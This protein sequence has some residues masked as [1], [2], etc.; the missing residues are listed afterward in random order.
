MNKHC[1]SYRAAIVNGQSMLNHTI[2]WNLHTGMNKDNIKIKSNACFTPTRERS[3]PSS[4]CELLTFGTKSNT[5]FISL[6]TCHCKA[7]RFT[8]FTLTTVCSA[9]APVSN[10]TAEIFWLRII[11]GVCRTEPSLS[12]IDHRPIIHLLLW[13]DPVVVVYREK[14]ICRI[15]LWHEWKRHF[16]VVGLLWSHV[17]LS[18]SK[19]KT[20]PGHVVEAA[21]MFVWSKYNIVVTDV[22]YSHPKMT[23]VVLLHFTLTPSECHFNP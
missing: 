3:A 18:S 6:P 8:P 2:L 12:F 5:L 21:D 10:S 11:I 13:H 14:V 16:L 15:T 7:G 20:H 19:L 17:L 1:N 4:R 23:I 22:I 9:S